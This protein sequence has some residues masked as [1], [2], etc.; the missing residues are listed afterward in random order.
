MFPDTR[1]IAG[2]SIRH[3]IPT[4]VTTFKERLITIAKDKRSPKQDL[5]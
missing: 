3:T 5:T 2:V 4:N 1:E